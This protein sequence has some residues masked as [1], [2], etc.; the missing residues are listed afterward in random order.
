[1]PE[2][3]NGSNGNGNISLKIDIAVLKEWRETMERWNELAF[4]EISHVSDAVE[5]LTKALNK[6]DKRLTIIE[7][8]CGAWG[9]LASLITSAGLIFTL[10]KT[11]VLTVAQ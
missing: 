3:D 10:I 4:D 5:K 2:K 7:F 1:M 9:A 11:G 6:F 8:K